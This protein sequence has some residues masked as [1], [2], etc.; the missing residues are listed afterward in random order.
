MA[1]PVNPYLISA[2][3]GLLPPAPQ[4]PAPAGPPAP[5]APE[6]TVPLQ[7]GTA[8]LRTRGFSTPAPTAVFGGALAEPA[9]SAEPVRTPAP[10][11]SI[12]LP[13][14]ARVPLDAAVVLGRDP[15]PTADRPT[16]R[17][18]AVHDARRSVSKTHALVL[19]DGERILV[20]D[21]GSTNGTWLVRPD[22]AVAEATAGR[23]VELP[24]GARIELGECAVLVERG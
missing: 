5:A 11:H 7:T 8:P 9:P 1:E 16:A 6:R 23:L 17:P 22:G 2:P 20:Q 13:D 15:S 12:V 4:A 18:V 10:L 21:L 24:A 19:V 14:G 3:P